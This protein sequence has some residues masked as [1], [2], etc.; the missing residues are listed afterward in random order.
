[1]VVPV[2][3]CWS[4]VPVAWQLEKT[5]NAAKFIKFLVSVEAQSYFVEQ[6]SEYPVVDGV[7]SPAGLTPIEK[8]NR[9]SISLSD[10]TD[11]QGTVG[12]LQDVGV[13]P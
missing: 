8:L 2:R 11:M 4:P 1:M 6:T 13:L 3:W 10:L 7:E 9:A 5:S 12:L